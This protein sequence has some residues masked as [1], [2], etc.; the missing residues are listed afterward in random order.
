MV[1]LLSLEE[2]EER[3]AAM[4]LAQL[5]LKLVHYIGDPATWFTLRQL[6]LDLYRCALVISDESEAHDLMASDRYS[7]LLSIS[8]P[9]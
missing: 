2:R 9:K 6:D 4:D 7:I 3:L 1:N 8:F 5:D